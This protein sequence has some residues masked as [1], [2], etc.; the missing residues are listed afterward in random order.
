MASVV[1]ICVS[2]VS[3]GSLAP[4][5]DLQRNYVRVTC[6][7]AWLVQFTVGASFSDTF[8]APMMPF[9][10]SLLLSGSS[11]SRA[12]SIPHKAECFDGVCVPPPFFY[13]IWLVFDCSVIICTHLLVFNFAFVM[14]F[15]VY[16]DPRTGL[17]VN[18]L[19]FLGSLFWL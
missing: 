17:E 10:F 12:V 11:A 15:V 9:S 4:P 8:E 3:L 18:V 1:L 13:S 5:I 6:V 2:A 7:R 14:E 16:G 19:M